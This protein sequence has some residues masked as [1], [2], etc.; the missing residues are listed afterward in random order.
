MAQLSDHVG[1]QSA[2]ALAVSVYPE[3]QACRSGPLV[4]VEKIGALSPEAVD[5]PRF[6][7]HFFGIV[8]KGFPKR[9]F[10]KYQMTDL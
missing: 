7:E 9:I 5:I 4:V 3:L 8:A 1:Y 6:S 10:R 2:V